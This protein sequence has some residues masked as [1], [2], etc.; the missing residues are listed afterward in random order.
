M[1]ERENASVRR[2]RTL[3]PKPGFLADPSIKPAYSDAELAL[4]RKRDAQ[5]GSNEARAFAKGSVERGKD[6]SVRDD[7]P[8]HPESFFSLGK[9]SFRA[10]MKTR[11]SLVSSRSIVRGDYAPQAHRAQGGGRR[12]ARGLRREAR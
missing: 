2:H 3:Q 4:R 10:L 1:R 6:A 12:G 9:K 8:D 7:M 5:L 11:P